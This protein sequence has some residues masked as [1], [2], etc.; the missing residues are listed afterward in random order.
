[1][2]LSELEYYSDQL[3]D[4]DPRFDLNIKIKGEGGETKWLNLNRESAKELV[5]W[6][7]NKFILNNPKY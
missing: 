3:K 1:M 5:V 2:T 7:Q 6:L 4:L